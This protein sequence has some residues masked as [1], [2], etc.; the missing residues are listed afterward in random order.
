[1]SGISEPVVAPGEHAAIAALAA[2]A[3]T[4]IE[5]PAGAWPDERLVAAIAHGP[6]PTAA[7]E[8]LARVMWHA[9]LRRG[10]SDRIARLDE[11][12]RSRVPRQVVEQIDFVIASQIVNTDEYQRWVIQMVGG[13]LNVNDGNCHCFNHAI[14]HMPEGGAVVEIGSFL[15][16]SINVLSY[17]LLRF[18]RDNRLFNADPWVFEETEKPIGG[19]FDAAS[20]QYRDY[21]VETYK[22]NVAIFSGRNLPATVEAFSDDFFRSWDEA[23]EVTD[24]FGNRVRLGGPISFAYIDGAHTYEAARRDFENAAR[25]LLPGGFILFDDSNPRLSFGCVRAAH[26]AAATPGYRRLFSHVDG[27]NVLIEKTRS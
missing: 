3:P 13:W 25:H 9:S 8:A 4:T 1:M 21:C 27:L 17:L 14:R 20:R 15:G 16:A 2:A 19:F 23:A 11:A 22:R 5:A 7:T 18:K 26:E 12:L 10:E 6:V 24:I